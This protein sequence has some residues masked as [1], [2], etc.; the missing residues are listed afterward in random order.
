MTRAAALVGDESSFTT[1]AELT[2]DG[3]RGAD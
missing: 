3:E 2:V 1:G